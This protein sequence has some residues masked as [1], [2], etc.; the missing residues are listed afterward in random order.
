VAFGAGVIDGCVEPAEASARLIDQ[1]PH[2]VFVAHV[3]THKLGLRAERAQLRGQRLSGFLV[4]TG[5]DD[6]TASLCEGDGGRAADAGQSAS[7]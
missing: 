5:D 4:A 6:P 1:L 3:S 7:N 2:I